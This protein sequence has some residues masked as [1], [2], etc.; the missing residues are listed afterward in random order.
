MKPKL[1]EVETIE[2]RARRLMRTK[3]WKESLERSDREVEATLEKLR[4]D[5]KVDPKLLDEPADI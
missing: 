2:A 5:S 3:K 1:T 4:Q